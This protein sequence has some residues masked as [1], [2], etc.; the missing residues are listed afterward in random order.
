MFIELCFNFMSIF[1]HLFIMWLVT[2]FPVSLLV[3]VMQ[4]YHRQVCL[5]YM[6]LI[7]VPWLL[8]CSGSAVAERLLFGK[9]NANGVQSVQSA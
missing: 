7:Y 8:S 1:A 9:A 3:Q 5:R 2:F 6:W 4:S